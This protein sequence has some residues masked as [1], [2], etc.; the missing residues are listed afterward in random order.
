MNVLLVY[1]HPAST[2]LNGALKTFTVDRLQRAEV[3]VHDR[4]ISSEVL[5]LIPASA[6]RVYVGKAL[7]DH[8]ADGHQLMAL[9]GHLQFA[10]LGRDAFLQ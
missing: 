2:S 10:M 5:D 1:A 8:A 3:V 7:G 6:P 9:K 4:L